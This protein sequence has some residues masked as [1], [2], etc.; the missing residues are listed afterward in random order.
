[1]LWN[2]PANAHDGFEIT[3]NDA[4]WLLETVTGSSQLNYSVAKDFKLILGLVYVHGQ[5]Y[6]TYRRMEIMVN[7]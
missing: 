1:M 5:L 2:I 7:N 6:I 4:S 3:S